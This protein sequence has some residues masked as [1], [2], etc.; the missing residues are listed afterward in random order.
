[1][2]IL[3]SEPGREVSVYRSIVWHSTVIVAL[4]VKLVWL[5]GHLETAVWPTQRAAVTATLAVLLILAAPTMLAS[6]RYRRFTLLALSVCLTSV[7]LADVLHFRFYGDVISIAELAHT[8]QLSA[9]LDSVVA[10]LRPTDAFLYADVA[11]LSVASWSPIVPRSTQTALVPGPRLATSVLVAGLMLAGIPAQLIWDDPEEV[12]EYATT[13]REVA[14]AIG[15]IPHHVYDLAIHLAHPVVGR[16]TV[17]S[18]D[19]ATVTSYLAATRYVSTIGALG[20]VRSG[21]GPESDHRDGGVAARLSDRPGGRRSAGHADAVPVREGKPPIR[22][23]LRPNPPGY[24]IRRRVHVTT[25][26]SP[27]A[28]RGGL[29]TLRV[30]QLPRATGGP[31]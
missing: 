30:K 6:W 5:S 4:L 19:R 22:E 27:L 18:V 25:E 9:L 17:D 31:A 28:G 14:V 11:V 16:L 29:D 2:P 8:R 23:L 24:D 21:E 3:P 20:T 1:M 13:R 7:A 12:F 15:I 10:M 26:S